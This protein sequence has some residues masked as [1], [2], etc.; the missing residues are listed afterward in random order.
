MSLVALEA[1]FNIKSEISILAL[2]I[3]VVSPRTIKLPLIVTLQSAIKLF[4]I[5]T[6]EK[7]D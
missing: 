2:L 5:V 6:Y 4:C 3:V 1:I 7:V